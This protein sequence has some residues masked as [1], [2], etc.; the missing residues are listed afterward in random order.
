[1]KKLTIED[2]NIASNFVDEI[3]DDTEISEIEYKIEKL[4]ERYEQNKK[5]QFLVHLNSIF[6]DVI[7]NELTWRCNEAKDR[8]HQARLITKKLREKIE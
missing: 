8:S 2:F 4:V 3:V 6:L 7:L 1:M 5:K